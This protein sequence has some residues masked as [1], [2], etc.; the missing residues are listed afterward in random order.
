MCLGIQNFI[1]RG[2]LQILHEYK[3]NKEGNKHNVRTKQFI[4]I[5]V[6]YTEDLFL[7]VLMDLQTA[8]AA[9]AH[10]AAGQWL[11]EQLDTDKLRELRAGTRTPTA[12]RTGR[13]TFS[14]II[15]IY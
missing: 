12:S 15:N 13:P 5:N 3:I 9:E 10:P 11:Q 14:A 7:K 2:E 8:L 4:S 6:I 1:A